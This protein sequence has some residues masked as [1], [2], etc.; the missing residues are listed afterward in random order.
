M[1]KYITS[2]FCT[3][4]IYKGDASPSIQKNPPC[5][6]AFTRKKHPKAYAARLY[7][8]LR[9]LKMIMENL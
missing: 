1:K 7:E 2:Q 4:I 5:F 9:I 6:F 3:A 8:H